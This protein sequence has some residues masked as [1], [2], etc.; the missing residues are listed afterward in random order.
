MEK[1][2]VMRV[3]EYI[4]FIT[5]K[6]LKLG[7]NPKDK[8]YGSLI[9]TLP[10]GYNNLNAHHSEHRFHESKT[11]FTNGFMGGRSFIFNLEDPYNPE[12][13][14]NFTNMIDYLMGNLNH[15]SHTNKDVNIFS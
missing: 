7:R 4:H 11:L 15:L 1:V 13:I 6:D 9:K 10:V 2:V 14:T 12:L 8:D 3:T 5:R